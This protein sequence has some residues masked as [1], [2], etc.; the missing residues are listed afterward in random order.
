MVLTQRHPSAHGLHDAIARIQPARVLGIAGAITLN[1]AA[2]ML[3][4]VPVSAP[5]GTIAEDVIDDIFVIPDRPTPPPPTPPEVPVQKTIPTTTPTQPVRTQP[6]TQVQTQSEAPVVDGGTDYVPPADPVI[7][8]DPIS[9]PNPGPQPS[10]RLEYASA[11]APAYP[12]EALGRELEGTVMLKV[13]VDVDGSPLSVEIERS[14]GH[15]RLDDAARR[16]VLRKW[17]FKPAIKDGQAIQVY[18]IVPVS[19]TLTRG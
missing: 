6:Q 13:L 17:K 9:P 10:T 1:A 5:M 16:Q 12:P 3:L 7:D 8:T 18:G 2:L 14:S 11:P 19:F 15:R 4:L